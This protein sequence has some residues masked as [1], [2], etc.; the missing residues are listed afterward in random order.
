[1]PTEDPTEEPTEVTSE[2]PTEEPTE[3][4]T[5]VPTQEPTEEPTEEPTQ[6]PTE[7]PTPVPTPTPLPDVRVSADQSSVT[8]GDPIPVSGDVP[9]PNQTYTLCLA[10]N[11]SW[12][13]GESIDCSICV[14]TEE[15]VPPDG[16]FSG[17]SLPGTSALGEYDVLLLAGSCNGPL[18]LI[19]ADDAGPSRSIVVALAGVAIPGL[20]V[21]VAIFLMCLLALTGGIILRRS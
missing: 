9:Y 13:I 6:S 7:S 1:M 10:E 19:A 4:P 8:Q 12:T 18:E 15:F 2:V 14:S 3:E 21:P 20:M 16:S 11:A 17:I 5:E